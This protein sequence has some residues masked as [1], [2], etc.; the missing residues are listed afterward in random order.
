MKFVI[1]AIAVV[2]IATPAGAVRHRRP[3]QVP[4]KAATQIEL[5]PQSNPYLCRMPQ[6]QTNHDLCDRQVAKPGIW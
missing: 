5:A 3:V 4:V 1:T 6:W 2:C